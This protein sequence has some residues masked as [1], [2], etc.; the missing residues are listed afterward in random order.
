MLLDLMFL[1]DMMSRISVDI[2]ASIVGIPVSAFTI[3]FVV[4]FSL[5]ERQYYKNVNL[6]KYLALFNLGNFF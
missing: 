3:P 6:F 4:A 1:N 5:P 2:T